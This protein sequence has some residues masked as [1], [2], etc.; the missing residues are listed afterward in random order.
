MTIVGQPE[1]G[2]RVSSSSEWNSSPAHSV[3]SEEVSGRPLLHPLSASPDGLL[4]PTGLFSLV[5]TNHFP[6]L[7]MAE[8]HLMMR[9]RWPM[10][11]QAATSSNG[12]SM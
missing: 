1:A 11:A 12:C 3:V 5:H 8:S 4:P 10:K 6:A 9:E 7:S 2:P